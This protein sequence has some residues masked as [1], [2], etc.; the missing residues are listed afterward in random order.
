MNMRFYGIMNGRAILE[1]A[2]TKIN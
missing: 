2:L 1:D